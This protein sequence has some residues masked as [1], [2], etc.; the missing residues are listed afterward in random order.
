M[1]ILT[2]DMECP[3]VPVVLVEAYPAL[4]SGTVHGLVKLPWDEGIGVWDVPWD[5]SWAIEPI[6]LLRT[7]AR[8]LWELSSKLGL[9]FN[10]LRQPFLWLSWTF[11]IS[12]NIFETLGFITP[13][14]I[15]TF[16]NIRA[17]RFNFQCHLRFL[18]MIQMNNLPE[19]MPSRS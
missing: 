13:P 19:V 10:R 15:S 7:R 18:L 8:N 3:F 11:Y 1:S 14:T 6:H 16:S 4:L 2:F 17:V 9:V 12:F 5:A